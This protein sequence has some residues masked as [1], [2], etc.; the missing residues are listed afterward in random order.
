MKDAGI[1]ENGYILADDRNII[2]VGSG[3]GY[4]NYIKDGD[5]LIDGRGKTATPGLIDCHTHVVYSGSR[6][7]EL[8]L[9]L[10][11][12]SYIEILNKGGGILS[13]V[14]KTRDASITELLEESRQRL[15]AMLLHGTTTIES[16]SGYGLNFDDEIKMLTVNDELN[17]THYVDV[18]S[19]YLGAHAIPEEYK[20]CRNKYI[21]L[22][23]LP[24]TRRYRCAYRYLPFDFLSVIISGGGAVVYLSEPVQDARIIEHGFRKH[25]LACPAVSHKAD[26]TQLLNGIVFHKEFPLNLVCIFS[27]ITRYHTCRLYVTLSKDNNAF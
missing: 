6:E 11:N 13:S 27:I 14:R 3:E 5:T 1:I 22:I 2:A 15:D 10:N 7:N 16:K 9:K 21:D 18:M 19:T 25:C 26:I 20:N 17:K 12:V 4:L 8:P 24:L 23:I